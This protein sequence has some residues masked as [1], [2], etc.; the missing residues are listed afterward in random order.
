M[1]SKFAILIA[2]TVSL[3]AIGA[4]SAS[5]S[6]VYTYTGMAFVDQASSP[7]T[8]QD[9]VTASFIFS[10][11]LGDNMPFTDVTG[12]ETSFTMSD[13]VQKVNTTNTTSTQFMFS[14]DST[15]N[16]RDWF[17]FSQSAIG[18]I[19][20]EN[21]FGPS[22]PAQDAGQSAGG[23]GGNFG[24]PGTWTV[25]VSQTPLP[26]AL[27]LFAT[28]LAMTGLLGWRKK[29]KSAAALAAA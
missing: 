26:A 14:T 12:T 27:P 17:L 25:S 28:G 21:D 19:F 13:G 29:R 2:A 23:A 11:A 15:G 22:N 7:Y 16:I 5:A 24:H 6:T 10:T 18:F 20:S 4:A 3:S 1:K 9:S 8:T